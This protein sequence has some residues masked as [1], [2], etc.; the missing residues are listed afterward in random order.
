MASTQSELATAFRSF[1]VSGKPIILT[2][3]Y[4]AASAQAIADIPATR[5]L[6]TASYAVAAAAGSS[7]NDLT[8]E[9]NLAAVSA[10]APIAKQRGLPLTVDFQ[11]GYGTRL[12]EGIEKLLAH[13]VVGINLEDYDKTEKKFIPI[14]DAAERVKRVMTVAKKHGI[15][16]FV[17][18]ARVDSM[19]YGGT[20]AEAI[21]RGKAYLA[22]GAT[23]IFGLGPMTPGGG[24]TKDDVKEFVQAFDGKLNVSYGQI[25]F[26]IKELCEL[27][28][29]RISVGPGLQM[30]A[31]KALKEKAESILSSS[32]I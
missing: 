32:G 8:L 11:D 6:A 12:E 16:D 29:S 14:E 9:T 3:V 7:D 30:V 15:E 21:T 26:P 24:L 4:D 28:V 22:A 18:N 19:V 10:I 23:T 2:N 31:M 17:V 5:A 25:S 20:M 27:G 1:H 13:G